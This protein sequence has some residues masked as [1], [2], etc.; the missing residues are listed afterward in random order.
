MTSEGSE[1]TRTVTAP[2][3]ASRRVGCAGFSYQHQPG[4]NEKARRL[5]GRPASRLPL[6]RPDS[7]DTPTCSTLFH[8]PF[9]PHS[10]FVRLVLN[11]Y[12]VATRLI[13]ERIW[14][15]RRDFLAINPAGTTPVLV[16]EG[17]PPVPGAGIIAEYLDETLRRR[18]GRAPAAAAARP[19]SGSRCAG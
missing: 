16:E 9:C 17:L 5:H 1:R 7:A 4:G 11:E 8:H 2:G 18:P 19:A 12:G 13:E 10:R 15:R 3:Q 6:D 14:E